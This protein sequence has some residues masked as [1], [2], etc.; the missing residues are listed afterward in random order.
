MQIEYRKPENLKKLL[1]LSK[2]YSRKSEL[3]EFENEFLKSFKIY[4]KA[5]ENIGVEDYLN[6][7]SVVFN[8]RATLY[9]QLNTLVKFFKKNNDK[10]G[11]KLIKEV[12]KTDKECMN[13][14][15]LILSNFIKNPYNKLEYPDC[16]SK[17]PNHFNLR[18]KKDSIIYRIDTLLYL[19]TLRN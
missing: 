13:D 18:V 11:I 15:V 10:L 3:S 14:E 19:D 1:I 12:I 2:R 7:I 17:Y 4:I 5:F 16:N 6:P 9:Y 8:R